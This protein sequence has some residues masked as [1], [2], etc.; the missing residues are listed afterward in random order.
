LGNAEFSIKRYRI[1]DTD[2]LRLVG[3]SGGKGGKVQLSNP[4]PPPGVELIVLR[5]R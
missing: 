5:R 3:E 1:T 2:D 4:L